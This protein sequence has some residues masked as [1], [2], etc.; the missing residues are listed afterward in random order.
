[1]PNT[2]NATIALTPFDIT[3]INETFN[4]IGIGFSDV[5]RIDIEE[6]NVVLS[7]PDGE[8]I[9]VSLEEGYGS[10]I[11]APHLVVPQLIVRFVPLTRSGMYSL[12]ITPQ[13]ISGNV[14]QSATTY[15]FRLDLQVPAITSVNANTTDVAIALTPF[16]IIDITETVNSI[17]IGFSDVKRID[18]EGTNVVLSGPDGE[19]IVVSIEEGEGSDIVAPQLVVRFVPLAQS[20]MYRLSITPQDRLG[21][22]AQSATTYQ[23]RLDLQV[24]A[25]TSVNANIAD[26]HVALTLYEEPIISHSFSSFTLEFTDAEN[27]DDE[28][29]LI[30]LSGPKRTRD[31]GYA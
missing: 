2:A 11:V 30:G 28:N 20:G 19:D 31:C 25:I 13:D 15:Q 21:N 16:E 7:G 29:T 14:A 3:D 17:G 23:F 6:I 24:P 18:I 26:T 9:A 5:K 1:M 22:I 8:G 12:S 27:L 10:H 4:S